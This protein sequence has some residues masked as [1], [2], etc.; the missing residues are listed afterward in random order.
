VD[1]IIDP[2]ETKKRARSA[3]AFYRFVWI[4]H[5]EIFQS[6]LVI[7]SGWLPVFGRVSLVGKVV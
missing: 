1:F 5:G 6:I 4:K 3:G 7:F 2:D